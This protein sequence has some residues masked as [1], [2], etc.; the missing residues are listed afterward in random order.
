M[1]FILAAVNLLIT[2]III[3]GITWMTKQPHFFIIPLNLFL[4]ATVDYL[5]IGQLHFINR[6][7]V[8]FTFICLITIYFFPY[9][10]LTRHFLSITLLA[11]MTIGYVPILL[12]TSIHSTYLST[13]YLSVSFIIIGLI[14]YI[15][16][17]VD[18]KANDKYSIYNILSYPQELGL[19]ILFAA[20]PI[21]TMFMPYFY[22]Y[23]IWYIFLML[24]CFYPIFIKRFKKK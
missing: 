12:N 21:M 16:G 2:V 18:Q 13:A 10:F 22:I 7:F 6:L 11:V 20:L 17:A 1:M 15:L 5:L 8:L 19:I 4:I 14:L 3:A 24:Y 9:P 23:L